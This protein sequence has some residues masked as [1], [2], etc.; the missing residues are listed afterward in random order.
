[1]VSES[2]N[3]GYDS[4]FIIFQEKTWSKKNLVLLRLANLL[5]LRFS[6][7]TEFNGEFGVFI[8]PKL[9]KKKN[10]VS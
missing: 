1:M 2:Q 5:I 4:L 3:K 8:L 9:S 7:N 10:H 6:L